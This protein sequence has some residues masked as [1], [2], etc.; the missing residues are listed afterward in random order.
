MRV[1]PPLSSHALLEVSPPAPSVVGWCQLC[2]VKAVCG[3]WFTKS[4]VCGATVVADASCVPQ[5]GSLRT[6]GFSKRDQDEWYDKYLDEVGP[7]HKF[8][9]YSTSYS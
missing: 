1:S 6:V 2:V 9:Q 5:P 7:S 8:L 4:A 3:V